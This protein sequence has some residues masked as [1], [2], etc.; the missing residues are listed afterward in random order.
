MSSDLNYRFDHVHIYC[1]NLEA[2]KKWFVEKLGASLVRMR[3][4][5]PTPACDLSVGG[6]D[7][8]LREQ[9]PGETL[10]PGGPARFGTDHMGLQVDDLAATAKELKRRGVEF[11]VEPYEIRPGLKISFVTGPDDLRIELLE[12]AH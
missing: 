6:V 12:R 3:D 4:P 8:F 10:A 5:K 7:L 11:E 2:S 9:N 1:T